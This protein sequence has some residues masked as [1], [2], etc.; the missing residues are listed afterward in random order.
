MESKKPSDFL[1]Y[2]NKPLSKANI[3]TLYF[4]NNVVGYRT[5]EI[6]ILHKRFVKYRWK[7][8]AENVFF[9]DDDKFKK[10]I[11][12]YPKTKDDVVLAVI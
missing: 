6:I 11:N 10:V 8:K 12:T 5:E 7:K 3:S 4:T 1:N 9:F 2:I